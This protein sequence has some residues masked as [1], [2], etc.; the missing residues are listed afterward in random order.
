MT[1]TWLGLDG[2]ALGV[3][4]PAANEALSFGPPA[5]TGDNLLFWSGPGS[6]LQEIDAASGAIVR[7]IGHSSYAE[8]SIAQGVPGDFFVWE[9]AGAVHRFDA[10]G[11]D[12]GVDIAAAAITGLA[13][14]RVL[15][16]DAS[17]RFY[18]FSRESAT[19]LRVRRHLADGSFDAAI[20]V[21]A[22]TNYEIKDA[23]FLAGVSPNG[24]SVYI[25]RSKVSGF[26]AS[27]TTDVRDRLYSALWA[28]PSTQTVEYETSQIVDGAP[29]VYTAATNP[30]GLVEWRDIVGLGIRPSTGTP[31]VLEVERIAEYELADEAD[32]GPY[33]ARMILDADNHEIIAW[34]GNGTLD[35]FRANDDGT[36]HNVIASGNSW[37]VDMVNSENWF[38]EVAPYSGTLAVTFTN[39]YTWFLGQQLGIVVSC[40]QGSPFVG[41]NPIVH[42]VTTPPAPYPASDSVDLAGSCPIV[43]GDFVYSRSMNVDDASNILEDG[44]RQ[45]ICT[46]YTTAVWNR[47]EVTATETA[48]NRYYVGPHAAPVLIQTESYHAGGAAEYEFGHMIAFNRTGAALWYVFETVAS[49]VQQVRS[50]TGTDYVTAGANHTPFVA[51]TLSLPTEPFW[52]YWATVARR[53]RSFAWSTG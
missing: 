11:L 13:N 31:C 34:P 36:A 6:G 47:V 25:V 41:Y 46:I 52:V 38:G 22:V 18:F 19:A 8:G 21:P 2:I 10:R 23:P 20:D 40:W 35:E 53:R 1:G 27:G 37:T 45:M 48:A 3:G 33:A 43:A 12:Q 15:H 14:P 51:S 42:L 24:A 4:D 32:Q 29:A 7:T 26:G 44:P 5:I 50:R 28:S 30:S 16:M 49:E 39:S 9:P 17:G